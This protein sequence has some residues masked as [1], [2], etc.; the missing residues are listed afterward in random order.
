MRLDVVDLPDKASRAAYKNVTLNLVNYGRLKM[1]IHAEA[2]NQDVENGEVTAFIRLGTDRNQNY[3]EIEVPLEIT[4]PGT[5][6]AEDRLIWPLANEVDL[7]FDELYAIKGARDRTGQPINRRFRGTDS[8]GRYNLYVRGN[9]D[10]SSVQTMMI[11]LRNPSGGNDEDP[12]TVII[13]VNELRVADFNRTRGWAANARLN[14]KLAD[15]GTVSASTSYSSIGFGSIQ[16]KIAERSLHENLGYDISANIQ[17]DKFLP[18]FLGLKVP[19]FVS[20]EHNT[21]RPKFNPYNPDITLRETLLGIAD[22]EER[23]RFEEIAIAET[24]RR[25]LNFTNVRK[26]KLK[27]NSVSL[28]WDIE[29]FSF[30]YSF[31]E[32]LRN[33]HTTESYIRRNYRGGVAY[34]YQLPELS[35]EPFKKVGFLK[36]DWFGLLRDFN[37]NPLISNVTVRGDLDRQFIRTQLWN[38]NLTTLGIDPQYEK[39]FNFRRTYNVRWNLTKSLSLDYDARANAVIDEPEGDLNTQEKRDS[40]LTNLRDLGRLKNFDQ[41]VTATYRVPLD[42]FPITSW[43]RTDLRYAAG[44]SW[45]A[46]AIEQQD[47]LGNTLQN[48]RDRSLTTKLDM[49]GLYN[50]VPFLK[51]INSPPRQTNRRGA[52]RPVRGEAPAA[53]D[54][55]EEAK[56]EMKGLKSFFR[57]LMSLRSVDF[58]YSVREGTVL[59]GYR[60]TPKYFGMNDGWEAPGW[61]FLL[62]SQDPDIRFDAANNDWLARSPFL[63]DFFT[64]SQTEQISLRAQLEP[65]KD[66]RIQLDAKKTNTA[67]YLESFLFLGDTV[68][69]TSLSP[70]RSGQYNIS[71]NVIRTAF[72]KENADGSSPV[73]EQ[74]IQNREIIARRLNEQFGTDSLFALNSQD[75]I[76]PA[77]RAAYSGESA[78]ETELTPFP[79]MP[80]PNWRVDYAGLGKIKKLSEIFSSINIT[81]GYNSSYDVSNFNNSLQY[82]EGLTVDNSIGDYPVGTQTNENGQVVPVYLLPQVTI[83][84]QFAPLIGV[85]VRTKS[86]ITA[87]AEYKQER[88]LTLNVGN[89][90]V[91]EVQNNDVVLEFGMT[92]AGM[93]LPFRVDGRVVTLK[94]DVTFRMSLTL[95]DTKTTQRNIE[96]DDVV[97]AGNNNLQFRPTISYVLNDKLNLQ[98]YFERSVST[99]QVSNSYKNAVTAFGTQIRFSLAE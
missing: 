22:Q 46:R 69:F 81:H 14:T 70:S 88:N 61:D 21:R 34:T 42:K 74:F 85:N 4:P 92:K 78:S 38:D 49:V 16:Q 62:G 77:F 79:K 51:E 87:R 63:S 59:P 90:Q 73:F 68:G 64:Q 97:T 26:V 32:E 39:Y 44:V 12:K 54:S 17:V 7:A 80:L 8:E 94:N 58:N 83:R 30:N 13:W 15:V 6:A 3:Y 11:G 56:P 28:P 37:F 48:T 66:L 19:M 50:K 36:S 23:D 75:V 9:P 60:P 24:E 33:D 40:V 99:P 53:K 47:T 98:V 45:T 1:F 65:V 82:T 93:K 55:T 29:N 89:F 71:Y 25:S 91:T 18:R 5:S 86:R 35:I 84:E 43:I 72:Q 76:V 41:N 96:D 67:N 57:V 2:P 10:L 20:Y 52:A 31:S 95:R 27:E